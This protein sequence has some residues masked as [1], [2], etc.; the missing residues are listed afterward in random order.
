MGSV[1]QGRVQ[2]VGCGWIR[3]AG[4]GQHCGGQD[5]RAQVAEGGWA[6]GLWQA[7]PLTVQGL[8]GVGKGEA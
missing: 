7:F 6:A 8:W 4:G 3:R 5:Y 2:A 1:E